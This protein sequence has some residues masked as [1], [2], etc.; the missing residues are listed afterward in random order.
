[1][2]NQNKASPAALT[3]ERETFEKHFFGWDHS[4]QRA[5][6]GNSQVYKNETL[7]GMWQA[8]QARAKLAP[9]PSALTDA[10]IL[11]ILKPHRASMLETYTRCFY[12]DEWRETRLAEASVL[13]FARALLAASPDDQVDSKRLDYLDKYAVIAKPGQSVREAID[14]AMSATPPA[15]E[16]E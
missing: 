13:A 4:R 9:A 2:D 3:D 11:E 14:Q 5:Q 15:A 8:W 12:E 6:I 16:G 1:M 10:Q 7:E